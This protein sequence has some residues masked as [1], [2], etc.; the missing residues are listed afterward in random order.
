[1]R[2]WTLA[3]PG[4]LPGH[5]SWLEA[6]CVKDLRI[7]TRTEM[8]RDVEDSSEKQLGGGMAV[9]PLGVKYLNAFIFQFLKQGRW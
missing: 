7:S 9:A 1:M 5:E 6:H 3:S 8:S 4:A 2:F